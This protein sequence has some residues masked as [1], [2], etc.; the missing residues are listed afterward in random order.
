[1][2][3][4]TFTFS[5]MSVAYVLLGIVFN[6]CDFIL[7]GLSFSRRYCKSFWGRSNTMV[8]R[9]LLNEYATQIWNSANL[10]HVYSSLFLSVSVM[11]DESVGKQA[12]FYKKIFRT[13]IGLCVSSDF[14]DFKV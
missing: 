3:H 1:M 9:L 4:V 5:M 10:G 13:S 11:L 7:K 2:Y 12:L 8:Y 6:M 14:F